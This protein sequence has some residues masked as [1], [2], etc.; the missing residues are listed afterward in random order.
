LRKVKP[1]FQYA[2]ADYYRRVKHLT[3]FVLISH[4]WYQWSSCSL[5]YDILSTLHRRRASIG[6][7]SP[8]NPLWNQNTSPL[9]QQIYPSSHTPHVSI[10]ESIEDDRKIQWKSN[11]LSK[12]DEVQED[13]KSWFSEQLE[14]FPSW[15]ISR[16]FY[17]RSIERLKAGY[18]TGIL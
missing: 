8:L 18:R 2:Y 10:N 6:R 4:L 13:D 15:W 1:Q 5:H 7:S 16:Q 17:S 9:N 12:D 14:W 11:G 3:I